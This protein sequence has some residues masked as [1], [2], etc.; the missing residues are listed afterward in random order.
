MKLCGLML[1]RNLVGAV[2][3][4]IVIVSIELGSN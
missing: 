2:C 4:K 1:L 3:L